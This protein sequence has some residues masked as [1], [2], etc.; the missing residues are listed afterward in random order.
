MSIKT[1]TMPEDVI[2]NMLKTLP[3][4]ELVDIFWKTL[5]ESDDSPLTTEEKKEIEEAKIEFEKGET[6]KWEDLR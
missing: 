5:V 3:E 4:D 6:I 1:L 2:I